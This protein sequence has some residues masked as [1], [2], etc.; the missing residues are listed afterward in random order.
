MRDHGHMRALLAL[1]SISALTG[2]DAARAGPVVAEPKV[3]RI[4]P[5]RDYIYDHGKAPTNGAREVARRLKQMQR[6]ADKDARRAP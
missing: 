1:A 5:T 4:P 2:V 6:K 3:R